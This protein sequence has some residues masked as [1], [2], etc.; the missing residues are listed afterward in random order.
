[1]A[2]ITMNEAEYNAQG[3]EFKM[4]QAAIDYLLDELLDLKN[5]WAMA[6]EESRWR[7]IRGESQERKAEAR[8]QARIAEEKFSHLWMVCTDL[9]I[10]P[11]NEHGG[12]LI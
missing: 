8:Q 11:Q 10:I 9:G 5:R 6:A 4:N 1:M 3:Y 2:R 7:C 12:Y